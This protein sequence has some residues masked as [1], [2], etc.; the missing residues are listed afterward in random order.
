MELGLNG[1]VVL[2]SGGLKG[3]G[4]ACAH[5]FRD[6]GAKVGIVSRA[7]A[8]LDRAREALGGLRGTPPTSAIRS[9]RRPPSMP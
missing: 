3:I 7:Q 9:R 2:I 4:L 1:K 6:E 8:N 5:A